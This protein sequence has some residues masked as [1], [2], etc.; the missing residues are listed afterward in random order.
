ML[1]Y[2][3]NRK[4][5]HQLTDEQI[6]QDIEYLSKNRSLKQLRKDQFIIEKLLE[7]A[8]KLQNN[9]AISNLEVKQEIYATAIWLKL[10]RE[11]L[12]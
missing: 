6:Q 7:V 3:L 5:L 8:Y 11:G 10:E 12:I 9:Y 1:N 2:Q 4:N